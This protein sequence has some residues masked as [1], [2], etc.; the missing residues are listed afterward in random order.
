MTD[1]LDSKSRV[2]QNHTLNGI[3]LVI[4]GSG[5]WTTRELTCV[6]P[7][8]I[9]FCSPQFYRCKGSGI[10]GH[11]LYR[12]LIDFLECH[13]FLLQV[14]YDCSDICFDYKNLLHTF[15]I[16]MDLTFIEITAEF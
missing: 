11:C 3:I 4:R 8:S 6:V 7:G 14:A 13:T 9:E 2:I 1:L 12:F 10:L 5:F 16:F 15:Y